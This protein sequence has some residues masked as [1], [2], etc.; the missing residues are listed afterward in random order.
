MRT[1]RMK[2]AAGTIHTTKDFATPAAY[3]SDDRNIMETKI[4]IK[5][6][7]FISPQVQYMITCYIFYE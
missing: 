4:V 7:Y 2:S 1:K 6:L 5:S 3:P